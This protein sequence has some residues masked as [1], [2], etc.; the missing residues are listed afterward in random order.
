MATM[1]AQKMRL[2]HA[3]VRRIVPRKLPQFTAELGGM[4]VSK[5]DM[6]GTLMGFSY[7]TIEGLHQVVDDLTQE[8]AE[9]IYYLWQVYGVMMGIHPPLT[10]PGQ[11]PTFDYIPATLAEAEEFYKSYARRHYVGAEKN[12]DGVTLAAADLAMMQDMI[13]QVLR[14]L[15]F[16]IVPKLLMQDA[17]KP[18]AMGLV[19][20][21]PVPA[22]SLFKLVYLDLPIWLDGVFHDVATNRHGYFAGRFLQKLVNFGRGGPDSFFIPGSVV[23]MKEMG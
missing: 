22:Y 3:G 19:G 21:R 15:G 2:L 6:L 18:P 1:A 11:T 13:P 10:E 9:D 23:A 17:L 12:P 5:E 16:G 14:A 7:L 20:M 8:E 4:P